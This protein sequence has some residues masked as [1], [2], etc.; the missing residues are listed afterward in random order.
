MCSPYYDEDGATIYC[1]DALDVVSGLH[2]DAVVTDPPYSSGGFNECGKSDGSVGHVEGR[3]QVASRRLEVSGVAGV[4]AAASAAGCACVCHTR[5]LRRRRRVM[6]VP[7]SRSTSVPGSG[8][9]VTLLIVSS[10]W[11]HD[12]PDW[13]S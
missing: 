3:Q 9:T 12:G 10:V 4:D 2:A 7:R 11:S 8:K 5:C 1:G 6:H 13:G